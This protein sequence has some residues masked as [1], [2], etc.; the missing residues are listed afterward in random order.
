MAKQLKLKST[1][2]NLNL[3]RP[4]KRKHI[5]NYEDI[6]KKTKKK[7]QAKVPFLTILMK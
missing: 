4:S 6:D 2:N 1:L 5:N 3:V 7:L